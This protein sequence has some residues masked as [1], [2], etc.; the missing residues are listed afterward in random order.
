MPSSGLWQFCSCLLTRWF[1]ARGFFYPEDGGDTIL[2]NV[3]SIDHIYTAPHRRRH[4]S[5]KIRKLTHR[6]SN[7]G[8]YELC[9]GFQPKLLISVPSANNLSLAPEIYAAPSQLYSITSE[10]ASS[11][12]RIM[13]KPSTHTNILFWNARSIKFK[14]YEFINYLNASNIPIA[15]ISETHLQPSTKFKYPNYITY[16]SD[17]LNQRGGGTAI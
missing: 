1:F 4:H 6:T 11:V 16:R 5:S 13:G 17:R 7:Q 14:K 15:L 3:G 2:R 10:P 12:F 9:S 8:I